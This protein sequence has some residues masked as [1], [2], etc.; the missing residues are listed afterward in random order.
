V[1]ASV[2][3]LSTGIQSTCLLLIG[4]RIGMLS[5]VSSTSSRLLLQVILMGA[6]EGYRV[7]GGPLGEIEDALY[8]GGQ[9]DP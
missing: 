3:F 1:L 8:P 6:V 5:C 9:F 7:N 2:P 4:T